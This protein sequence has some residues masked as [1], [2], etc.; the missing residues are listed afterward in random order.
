MGAKCR[1]GWRM[2]AYLGNVE[3]VRRMGLEFGIQLHHS[4][5]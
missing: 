2:R 4:P 1:F 3:E 5:D